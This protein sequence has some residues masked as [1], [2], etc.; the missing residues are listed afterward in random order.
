M[1]MAS[2]ILRRV[3]LPLRNG[4]TQ[5]A[6]RSRK[7]RMSSTVPV[8]CTLSDP[9]ARS[10]A[11]GRRPTAQNCASGT[12]RRTSGSTCATKYSTASSFGS[13]S[14]EPVNTML[15]ACSGAPAEWK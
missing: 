5:T 13:Q 14:I 7:G 2:K 11:D 8:T 4:T 15:L 9:S 12:A 1:A 10:F 3:P 6:P